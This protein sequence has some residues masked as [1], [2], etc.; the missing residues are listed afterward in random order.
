[1]IENGPILQFIVGY[2]RTDKTIYALELLCLR[3]QKS[4]IVVQDE[5]LDS[6]FKRYLCDHEG[7]PLPMESKR[8]A[9]GCLRPDCGTIIAGA[10]FSLRKA[11][12]EGYGSVF[13]SDLYSDSDAKPGNLRPLFSM[14]VVAL[15][16]NA[17]VIGEITIFS[18]EQFYLYQ[19]LFDR[20]S[21]VSGYSWSLYTPDNGGGV[22]MIV[23]MSAK[24][25][26]EAISKIFDFGSRRHQDENRTEPT[27]NRSETWT[28]G[29]N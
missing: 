1:M 2:P 13:F 6:F 29:I 21:Y 23:R 16:M 10:D 12:A 24:G 4:L 17:K 3:A 8:V 25:F 27:F 14:C 15:S 19:G 9:N 26:F 7:V 5:S 18:Q 11:M 28:Y 20:F 22:G